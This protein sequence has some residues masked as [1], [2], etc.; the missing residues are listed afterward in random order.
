MVIVVLKED[1]VVKVPKDIKVLEDQNQED[2]KDLKAHKV[3]KEMNQVLEE[4]KDLE[5]HKDHKVI[6]V[7]HQ[8]D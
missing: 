4:A 6:K 8:Q 2:L 5:V 1:Q 3:I 7:L